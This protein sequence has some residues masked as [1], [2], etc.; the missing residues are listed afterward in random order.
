M[1]IIVSIQARRCIRG[2]FN[3]CILEVSGCHYNCGLLNDKTS[4]I[5]RKMTSWS[6]CCLFIQRLLIGVQKNQVDNY[7]C[8]V[9]SPHQIRP[10]FF[11]TSSS[12]DFL[13][14]WFLFLYFVF[15]FCFFLFFSLSQQKIL[16]NISTCTIVSSFVRID[17]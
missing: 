14:C 12:S 16:I 11:L 5:Y 9:W 4:S 15:V 8:L 3:L 10:G 6:I 2:R 17:K 7:R 1:S 13:I